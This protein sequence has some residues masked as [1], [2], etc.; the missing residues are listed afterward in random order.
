MFLVKVIRSDYWQ[1][2]AGRILPNVWCR[3]FDDMDFK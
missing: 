2:E 1:G 3:P